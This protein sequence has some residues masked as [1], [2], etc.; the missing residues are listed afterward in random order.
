MDIQHR[1]MLYLEIY[2]K[3]SQW[4]IAWAGEDDSDSKGGFSVWAPT[5]FWND[6]YVNDNGAKGAY[7]MYYCT[8][9]NA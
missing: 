8:S 1:G 4:F 6:N 2:R 9:S 5:V 7:M 3:K